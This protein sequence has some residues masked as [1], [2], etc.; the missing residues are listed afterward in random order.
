[1]QPPLARFIGMIAE[2]NHPDNG[3]TIRYGG[4][5]AHPEV[6]FYAKRFHNRRQPESDA[7]QSDHQCEIDRAQHPHL[8]AGEGVTEFVFSLMLVFGEKITCKQ[9]FFVSREPLR[10]FDAAV[11]IIDYPK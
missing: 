5:Q 7:V 4:N 3:Y 10:L 11:Q 8:T 1:M 2:K 6:T 9:R